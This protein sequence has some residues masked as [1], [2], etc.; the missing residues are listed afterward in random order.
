LSAGLANF[1][2]LPELLS[3]A[4]N[5]DTSLQNVDYNAG[6]DHPSVTYIKAFAKVH[7]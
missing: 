1:T 4:K 2:L 7:A 5:G 3:T 6:K